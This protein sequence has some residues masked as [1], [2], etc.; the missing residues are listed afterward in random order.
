[1][2]GEPVARWLSSIDIEGMYDAPGLLSP[3]Y[4]ML[5]LF[6]EIT[7]STRYNRAVTLMMATIGAESQPSLEDWFTNS[8]RASDLLCKDATGSYFLL[9]PETAEANASELVRRIIAVFTNVSISK[10]TLPSEPEVFADLADQI[11][12]HSVRKAA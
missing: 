1:M 9:L 8:L 2:N 12:V 11:T 10:A 3:W 7:R 4:F 6:E 5:R